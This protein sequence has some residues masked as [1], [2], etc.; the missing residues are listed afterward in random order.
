MNLDWSLSGSVL[1]GKQDTLVGGGYTDRFYS[2]NLMTLFFQRPEPA[3]VTPT[4]VAGSRSR[5]VT[6]PSLEASMGLSYAVGRVNVSSGYRWERYFDVIDG[7]VDT[8]KPYDRT[9]DGPYFKIAVG[10]GG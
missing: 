8:A 10:F 3:S 1:F 2:Q 9:I 7:G 6:V 5:N 4:P